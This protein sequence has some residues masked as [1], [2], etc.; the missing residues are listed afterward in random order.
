MFTNAGSIAAASIT[1][2]VADVYI[3]NGHDST[4]GAAAAA[5]QQFVSSGGGLVIGAHAWYWSYS[6]PVLQHPSNLV[7]LPMGIAVSASIDANDYTF[8]GSPPIQVGNLDTAL[9]C[10]ED[11]CTGITSS[12]CFM[13]DDNK[14]S[15]AMEALADAAGYFPNMAEFWGRLQQVGPWGQEK[16]TG[17]QA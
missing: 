5:I 6:K 8:T 2:A 4:V 16:H 13:A 9:Y 11:S 3:V 17:T 7:L 10:I 12:S 15:S 14:L 1:T